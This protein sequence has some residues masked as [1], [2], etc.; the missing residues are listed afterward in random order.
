V[1]AIAARTG[2]VDQEKEDKVVRAKLEQ[3]WLPGTRLVERL[4]H[5]NST[6]GEEFS[7]TVKV[8]TGLARVELEEAT[9]PEVF[10]SL[11]PLTEGKRVRKRRYTV[12]DEGLTW[13]VDEFLDRNLVLA[14]VEL[15]HAGLKPELPDWLA[16]AVVREVTGDAAYVNLNLAK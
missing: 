5:T 7:R 16:A 13:E 14:E 10:A 9:P 1:Q 8:G 2:L 12:H 3:G 6:Q 4:R 15:P 11:W